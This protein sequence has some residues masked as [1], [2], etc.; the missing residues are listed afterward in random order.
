M[1][2]TFLA[3]II[4]LSRVSTARVTTLWVG[5]QIVRIKVCQIVWLGLLG[6]W[7]AFLT[8]E[9][10]TSETNYLL[11]SLSDILTQI[12]TLRELDLELDVEVALAH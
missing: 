2:V 8:S 5:V 3:V 7:S 6:C 12:G 9:N 10:L 1:S 11:Q 4:I